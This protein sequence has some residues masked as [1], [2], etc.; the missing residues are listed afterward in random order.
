[1]HERGVVQLDEIKNMHEPHI[2]VRIRHS[3]RACLCPMV[4]G[5]GEMRNEN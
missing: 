5:V 4:Y 2:K 1:V 3:T